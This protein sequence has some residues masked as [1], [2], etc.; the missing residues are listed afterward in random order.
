LT[1]NTA[2]VEE[3]PA[4]AAVEPEAPPSRIPMEIALSAEIALASASAG[5]PVRAVLAAPLK[6][7]DRV[8]A[9]EGAPVTGAVVRLETQELPYRMYE[10]AI[11]LHTLET[12]QGAFEISATMADVR[13]AGG[14]IRQ[15]RRLDPTFNRRRAPRMDILVREVQRGQG[16]L[17]WDARQ[18]RIPKNLRMRWIVDDFRPVPR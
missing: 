14:L 12:P 10:I 9:P 16:V 13:P 17:H 11:E 8:L 2:A 18:G 15:A 3:S 4:P 6:D 7:G 1:F 5:D